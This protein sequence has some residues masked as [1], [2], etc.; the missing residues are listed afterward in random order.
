MTEKRAGVTFHV[1][2]TPTEAGTVDH[3][4]VFNVEHPLRITRSNNLTLLLAYYY[5][6]Y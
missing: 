1:W 4:C 2:T 6:L 5:T 3:C